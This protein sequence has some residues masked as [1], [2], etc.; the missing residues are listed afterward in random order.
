MDVLLDWEQK[1]VNIYLN[2]TY[3]GTANFYHTPV[4]NVDTIMMY[5]LNPGTTGFFSSIQLCQDKCP[6]NKASISMRVLT[7]IAIGFTFATKSII[8]FGLL[9]CM[10]LMIQLI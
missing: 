1:T 9:L 2:E 4:E 8:S 5:N 7:N 10:L 6:G 3:K